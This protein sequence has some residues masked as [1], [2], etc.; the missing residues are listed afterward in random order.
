[1]KDPRG[2]AILLRLIS[3]ATCTSQSAD[4][5][6]PRARLTYADVEALNPRLIYAS[7]TAYGEGPERDREDS[8]SRILGVPV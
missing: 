3:E 2:K 6:A 8:I 7:L 5:D 4:A 1:L